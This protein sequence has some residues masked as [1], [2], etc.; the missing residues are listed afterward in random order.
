M[1]AFGFFALAAAIVF[2]AAAASAEQYG[3][4]RDWRLLG[5]SGSGEAAEFIDANSIARGERGITFEA[6][7][8]FR[9]PQESEYGGYDAKL[10]GY[11]VDCATRTSWL[12]LSQSWSD[13]I[14]GPPAIIMIRRSAAPEDGT[15]LD[16]RIRSACGLRPLSPE[17]VSD[18]DRIWSR[19]AG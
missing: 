8:V 4:S 9:E 14:Q 17:R 3:P 12:E 10:F 11:S 19:P 6:L 16:V 5:Y 13:D 7:T 2:P 18:P 1:R 15:V